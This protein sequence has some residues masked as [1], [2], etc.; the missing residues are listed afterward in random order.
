MITHAEVTDVAVV[1]AGP[2]GLALAARLAQLG[3]AHVVVDADAGPTRES[4]AALVHAATLEI[5]DELGVVGELIAAGVRVNRI[6]FCDRGCVI[7]SIGLAG[8]PSRYRFALGVPQSTTERALAARLAALGGSIRQGHRAEKVTPAPEGYLVTGTRAAGAGAPA[9]AISARYV[10]GC[11]GAHSIVRSAAGLG[12]PGGTYPSQFVLADAELASPPGPD[13]EARIFTSPHGVVVTG[14]LPS[15]N[16]RIVATVD[17][18]VAVPDPPGRAF[19]DA[20]LRERGVGQLAADPVWSSRFRVHHRVAARFRAGG[21]FLCGDAAHVHSPAG[22]QGMNT[23]I[24]DAY[25]LATRLA[26]VLTG[27]ADPAVLDGYEHDRRPAA[28]EVVTFTDRMTTM[29]TVRSPAA[30]ALRDA[31]LAT[32]S[33]IPAV[34]NSLTLWVSGLKRSPLRHDLP[35]LKPARLPQPAMHDPPEGARHGHARG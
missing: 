4:R 25:D 20:I 5:L 34:R 33:R 15:G 30:R 32:A 24:A 22:G 17:T 18:G 29:A 12:F 10:I 21:V 2:T 6:G 27:Q 19:I 7:A 1:G 23:G 26:A 35:P 11:D 31:A 8:V 3:V 9:F 28:L 13:D 16:H 14:R